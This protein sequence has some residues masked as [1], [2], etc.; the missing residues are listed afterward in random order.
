MTEPPSRYFVRIV[1]WSENVR[2]ISADSVE[3]AKLLA[4]ADFTANG[5]RHFKVRSQGIDYSDIEDQHQF[6]GT[7]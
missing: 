5:S 4:E 6:G 1:S 7:A 2:W 3:E